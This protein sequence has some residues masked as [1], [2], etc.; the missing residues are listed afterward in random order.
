L[1][2]PRPRILLRP[3]HRDAATNCPEACGIERKIGGQ[4]DCTI[5]IF[6]SIQIKTI[7][8][9]E[10]EIVLKLYLKRSKS[11]QGNTR[12][13]GLILLS[14]DSFNRSAPSD[15]ISEIIIGS[16]VVAHLGMVMVGVTGKP[17]ARLQRRRGSTQ[18]RTI[19][20]T[21]PR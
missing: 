9:R 18:I 1:F 8:N 21:S 13:S 4:C 7:L 12:K 14:C 19:Y 2:I 6:E 16:A 10:L 17:A 5:S 11:S 15:F 3:R 20:P